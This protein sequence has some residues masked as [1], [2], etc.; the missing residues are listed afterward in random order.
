MN[1]S[2]IVSAVSI[3]GIPAGTAVQY[4]VIG[5][6]YLASCGTVV[7]L[8][9]A[10]LQS[11]LFR[12]QCGAV[13]QAVEAV[14]APAAPV[15]ETPAFN[16][17]AVLDSEEFEKVLAGVRSQK[18]IADGDRYF[19][20]HVGEKR[21]AKATMERTSSDLGRLL[22]GFALPITTTVASKKNR[23]T[24]LNKAF[25]LGLTADEISDIANA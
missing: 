6:P 12:T 1:A 10:D 25:G 3:S 4:S 19:F 18:A 17:S 8:T 7:T 2:T 13:V 21:Y 16:A 22:A 20:Y 15:D 14:A 5:T 23:L 24:N 9:A 11:S